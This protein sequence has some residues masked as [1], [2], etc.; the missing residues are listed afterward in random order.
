MRISS[1]HIQ[2]GANRSY[3]RQEE[4]QQLKSSTSGGDRVSISFQA[5]QSSSHKFASQWSQSL[6][7]DQHG[8]S[9]T[10]SS[11][12]IR[13]SSEEQRQATFQQ[14]P[15][16]LENVSTI[17]QRQLKEEEAL[18][19]M[20]SG[21]IAMADGRQVQ[22]SLEM[23]MERQFELMETGTADQLSYLADPLV[24]NFGGAPV[25]LSEGNYAFDLNN[26]GLAE[27]MPF[28][29]SGSGFLALDHNGDGLINNG[30]ELFGPSHGN[31]Y[32]ELAAYDSDGNGWLDENDEVYGKLQ[33]WSKDGLGNDQLRSLSDLGI[34]ALSLQAISTPFSITDHSNE[35]RGQ[36]RQSSIA[37]MENGQVS[38]MQQLDLRLTMPSGGIEQ[39]EE[40]PGQ[41]P[42]TL[43]HHFA[44][45]LD[46]QSA[47]YA[48]LS[49][50]FHKQLEEQQ[51]L[52]IELPGDMNELVIEQLVK[53]MQKEQA[54]AAG[55]H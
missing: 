55:Q 21:T 26:D 47:I 35:L 6:V 52:E 53:A 15:S 23:L 46:N 17:H 9:T 41:Q 4:R 13:D 32:Q 22:F 48:Q 28:T 19:L 33:V 42:T 20:G 51:Q 49:D 2:L 36:V 39:Q 43:A 31:G 27:Y 37:V 7:R 44:G 11:F 16:S 8:I 5:R 25:S 34:G 54:N 12:K 30:G 1:S 40:T 18:A 38:T 24:I 29:G 45:L 3:Q 50:Y 10:L 14:R